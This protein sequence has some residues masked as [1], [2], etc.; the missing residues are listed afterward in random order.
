VLIGLQTNK[1]LREKLADCYSWLSASDGR[2]R[3]ASK[4]RVAHNIRVV[5]RGNRWARQRVAKARAVWQQPVVPTP[6]LFTNLDWLPKVVP[7]TF[8][9]TQLPFG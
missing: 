4:F 5:V 3:P 7:H 9:A 6:A 8:H 2:H 1:I